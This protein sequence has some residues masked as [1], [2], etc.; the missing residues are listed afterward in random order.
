MYHKNY[1]FRHKLPKNN[2]ETNHS[3]Y[4]NIDSFDTDILH[5]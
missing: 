5:T 2:D 4:T 3:Y 1:A